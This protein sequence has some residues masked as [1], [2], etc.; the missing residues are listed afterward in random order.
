M[1]KKYSEPTTLV[2]VGK[3]RTS[4]LAGSNMNPVGQARPHGTDATPV[5][6]EADIFDARRRS[7]LD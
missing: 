5:G 2:K 6:G 7:S 1:K 4:I 3:I